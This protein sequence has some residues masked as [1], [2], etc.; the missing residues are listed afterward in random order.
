[1]GMPV[2][3]VVAGGIPVTEVTSG[4]APV[5]EATNKY[6]TPVTKVA[7]GGWPVNYG[8]SGGGGGAP[9]WTPA[10]LGA[11]LKGW[12]KADV[13]V[14][15]SGA[16]VTAVADQSGNGKTLTNSGVVPFSAT[17]FNGKPTFNFVA[18]NNAGLQNLSFTGLGTGVTGSVFIVGQFS[19]LANGAYGRA[20]SF[21][22][23]GGGDTATIANAAWIFIP[24]GTSNVATYRA[25]FLGTYLAVVSTNYRMGSIFDGANNIVYVNN[26]PST[27]VACAA[28]WG[29]TT[30][31]FGIGNGFAASFGGSAWDGP[32][33][34]IIVTNT[35]LSLAER[36]SLDGYFTGK[37]GI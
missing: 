12:W 34:E 18:A 19:P 14:T 33:S 10:D 32:I 20:V 4:G 2:V 23:T 16:N 22:G 30:A 27:P 6:G 5:T 28:P 31:K 21:D 8:G 1:M 35:A 11:A 3:T 36:N 37:Y 13:G 7:A 25:G 29:N 26:L 24:A 15:L 9:A 17:G